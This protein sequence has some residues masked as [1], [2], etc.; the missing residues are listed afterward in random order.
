M[1]SDF[2]RFIS[3]RNGNAEIGAKLWLQ[4]ADVG[5]R[6]D[7]NYKQGAGRAQSTV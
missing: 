6:I 1:P 5:G 7:I 2:C 4:N 3:A